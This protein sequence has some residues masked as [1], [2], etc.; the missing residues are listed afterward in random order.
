MAIT[1]RELSFSDPEVSKSIHHLF[2][3]E[4]QQKPK[5]NETLNSSNS[6]ISISI[7]TNYKIYGICYAKH[8]I[9]KDVLK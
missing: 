6:D 1:A 4:L 8:L 5:K 2:D 9:L 3:L 7:N